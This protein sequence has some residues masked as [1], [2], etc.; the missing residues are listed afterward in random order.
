MPYFTLVFLVF[1]TL[2]VLARLWLARRHFNHVS[3]HRDHVPSEFADSISLADHQKAA[4]YTTTRTRFG[5][6]ELL[7][8][9]AILLAWTLGGG[10]NAI[11]TL[12]QSFGLGPIG[13][14]AAV[15]ISILLVMGLLD[16]P[17][18]LYRT[19]VIEVR[20]G[21]NRT[22]L[23]M[24]ITDLAKGAALFAILGIPLI[25]LVLWLMQ[26]TGDYWWLYVWIAWTGFGLLISWAYPTLIAPLF[27]RFTPLENESLKQRIQALLQRSGFQSKGVFVMDGSR[28]S[29]HGNAYFTGLGRNKRI[30]FFDT[31]INKL[32]H[33]QIESVLAHELGHFKRKHVIKGLILSVIYSLLALILLAW[34]MKQDWFYSNLGVTTPS[35]HIALMLFIMVGPV[36]S[37]FIQPLL[38]WWSR[39]HEFEAD[40]FA[41][42]QTDAGN[43]VTALVSLYK[44]NAN[45]LTPDPLHSAV[46]DSHPPA[47]V[48]IAHLNALS[49]AH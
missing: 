4:D 16:L 22:T 35:V 5:M 7:V 20:F 31:L 6:L 2:S 3:Q 15:M 27:N 45:T 21:F 19:F 26:T 37:F 10:L 46:Y 43:L 1:L 18:S 33:E 9:S 39:K 47:S 38:T 44:E 29:S 14:G 32:S 41:A 48:R 24:F 49:H 8:D 11:D 23:K 30:V 36:F 12:W 42:Q 28:R 13:T 40:E 25:L 17:F 34:L